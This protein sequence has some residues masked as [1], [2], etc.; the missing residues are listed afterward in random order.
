MPKTS[1]SKTLS[2]P[3]DQLRIIGSKLKK[4]RKSRGISIDVAAK[5]FRI[6]IS[7]L[8]AIELGEKNY[9]LTLLVKMCEYYKV[10]VLDVVK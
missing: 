2:N 5:S 6:S 9:N 1:A 7:R 3:K 4:L 8:E 10:D